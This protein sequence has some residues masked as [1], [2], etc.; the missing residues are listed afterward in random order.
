MAIKTYLKSLMKIKTLNYL[1][2]LSNTIVITYIQC[3]TF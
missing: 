3:L 1:I 2:L